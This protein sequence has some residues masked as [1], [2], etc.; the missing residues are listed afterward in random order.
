MTRKLIMILQTQIIFG[1]K[2]Q[3]FLLSLLLVNCGFFEWDVEPDYEYQAGL[4]NLTDDTLIFTHYDAGFTSP[5]DLS[6]RIL[7]PDSFRFIGLTGVMKGEDPKTEFFDELRGVDSC[8]LFRF[9]NDSRDYTNLGT[10]Y[11][12]GLFQPS[13]QNLIKIWDGPF[14]SFNNE[15]KHYFNIDAWEISNFKQSGDVIL[16]TITEDI[17]LEN[18]RSL[19]DN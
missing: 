9:G 5:S 10:D 8:W 6:N 18:T 16:F 19:N 4:V 7:Y 1:R 14:R 3:L 15:K 12:S 2:A 13:R 17:L 11:P